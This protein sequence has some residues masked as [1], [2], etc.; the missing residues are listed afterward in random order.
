MTQLNK[1]QAQV[2]KLILD[3]ILNN[4]EAKRFFMFGTCRGKTFL[5]KNLEDYL[6]Y[7]PNANVEGFDGFLAAKYAA[8]K[9]PNG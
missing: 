5:L 9:Q 1:E 4:E 8:K 6:R 2:A 7:N 3:A